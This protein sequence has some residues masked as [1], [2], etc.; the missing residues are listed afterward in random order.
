VADLGEFPVGKSFTDT[1]EIGHKLKG[2]GA[3]YGFPLLTQL[4]QKLYDSSVAENTEAVAGLIEE[5]T[6]A[7]QSFDLLEPSE[8]KS[9]SG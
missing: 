6:R 8:V 2:N 5:I 9:Q 1:G 7:A 4:G 3:L